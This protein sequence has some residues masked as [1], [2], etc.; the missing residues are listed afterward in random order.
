MRRIQS[1][2]RCQLDIIKRVQR[3][4]LDVPPHVNE[5]IVALYIAMDDLVRV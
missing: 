4:Y 3:T 2:L 1:R 5:Y